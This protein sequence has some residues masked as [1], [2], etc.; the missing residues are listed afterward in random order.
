MDEGKTATGVIVEAIRLLVTLTTTAAGYLISRKLLEGSA[1]DREIIVVAGAVLGATVGYVVGGV[2]G[3]FSG[4]L[5]VDMP[6]IV[7]GATAPQLFGGA[8][9][10]GIGLM[11]AALRTPW[12]ETTRC[13]LQW[14]NTM[15]GNL[16]AATTLCPVASGCCC[17]CLSRRIPRRHLRENPALTRTAISRL[18][19]A[20]RASR[21]P[22]A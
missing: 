1:D 2:L 9:G 4:K 18:F 3:R 8:F 6:K 20:A 13:G 5:L 16:L 7:R 14:A 17:L 19:Q 12:V 21:R 10:V 11:V 15:P 22:C